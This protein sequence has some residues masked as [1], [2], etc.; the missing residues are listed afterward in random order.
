MPQDYA[1]LHGYRCVAATELADPRLKFMWNKIAWLLQAMN[2]RLLAYWQ[3]W[4][5]FAVWLGFVEK[6][7]QGAWETLLRR[8]T[9]F[10]NGTCRSKFFTPVMFYDLQLKDAASLCTGSPLRARCRLHD[11]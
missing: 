11:A 8:H 2:V 4:A 5:C 9:S 6:N 10:S 3:M 7:C 1:R